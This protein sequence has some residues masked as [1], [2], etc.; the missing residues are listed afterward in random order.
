M[1]DVGYDINGK[2]GIIRNVVPI[3]NTVTNHL[4]FGNIDNDEQY[5]IK[6]EYIDYVIPSDIDKE[7]DKIIS[8]ED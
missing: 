7:D 8:V 2:K 1:V 5:A 3:V 4:I 6:K